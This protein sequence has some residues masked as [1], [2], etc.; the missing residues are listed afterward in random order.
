MHTLILNSQINF[1]EGGIS[2]ISKES[3]DREKLLQYA[4]NTIEE[5]LR[6]FIKEIQQQQ[7]RKQ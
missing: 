4:T 5:Q 2:N 6:E 7:K 3:A 1:R